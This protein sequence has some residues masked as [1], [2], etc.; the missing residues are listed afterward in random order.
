M[1]NKLHF[2]ATG[3]TAAELIHDRADH[4]QPNMGLTSWQGDTVRAKDVTVAKNYLQVD[5]IDELNRIVTMWLDFAEDQARRRRQ[6]FMQDWQGKLDQFLEFN[7]RDVLAGHGRMRKTTADNKAKA[8]YRQFDTRRRA[9]REAEGE[10][11]NIRALENIARDAARRN[12]D[13]G[14]QS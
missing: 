4:A 1:Q 10:A 2:A 11:A 14:E 5:E 13:N 12:E 6:V 7:D 8:E 3:H 9:L